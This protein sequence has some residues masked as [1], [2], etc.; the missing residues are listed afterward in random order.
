MKRTRL[1]SAVAVLSV[2]APAI[3]GQDRSAAPA[4]VGEAGFRI[5]EA[6]LADTRSALAA[7]RVTSREVVT[8]YLIRIA[9]HEDRLNAALYVNPQAL[10]EADRLDRE[11]AQGTLRGPLHGIPVA[12]KDHI[13]TT[14]MP[15]TG[16][17][18]AF[19]G[20]SRYGRSDGAY[21]HRCRDHAGRAREPVSGS[22]RCGD[23]DVRASA[24]AGLYEVSARRWIERGTHRH[25]ARVLPT[26]MPEGTG[27]PETAAFTTAARA[28]GND[29]CRACRRSFP[30]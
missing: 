20:R 4:R 2:C 21:G 13:H 25:P 30:P 15:T 18:L 11:R 24:G 28:D 23:H 3:F 5:V 16:G 29:A 22:A 19:A 1:W 27:I 26:D 6:S 8:Q 7:R 12:L 17:A 9:T 10:D 14:D